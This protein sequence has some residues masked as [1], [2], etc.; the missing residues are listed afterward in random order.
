MVEGLLCTDPN[1]GCYT[2][3]LEYFFSEL[4]L[5]QKSVLNA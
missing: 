5:R 4:I 3:Y 1:M 2:E